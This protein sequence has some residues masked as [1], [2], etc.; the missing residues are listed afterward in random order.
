MSVVTRRLAVTGITSGVGLRLAEVALAAGHRLVGLVRDPD[1][2]DARRLGSL[3]VELVRGDLDDDGALASMARGA[4]AVLHLAA[5]VGD[6]GPAEQFVRVNVGGT[7]R[8]LHAA[9]VS[10]VRRFVHLSSTAVYGRPDRGQVDETWPTKHTGNPYDDTKVDAERLAFS[11]GRE[12]GLEVTAVR[13]PIIYGPYDKNFMP[14]A[15]AALRKGR[16]L[17]VA[18]GKAPLNV[19][20]VDHVV[21]V[22]LRAAAREGAVGEAFN[23]MDEVGGRPPSVVEVGRV[24]A[25]A[26]GAP[27]PTRSLPYPLALGLGHVALRAFTLAR[28]EKPPP[29]TPFV[30][31]ILTRDV[32][33]DASKA[34]RVLGWRPEVRALEGLRR[35]AEAFA[36]REG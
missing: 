10:G 33:Y 15:V 35:E 1:R 31:K 23:V 17:L 24:I 18:G 14:R 28:A 3:G 7:R 21:D 25:E 8:A 29:V 12:T 22:L 9:R 2:S 34:G 11:F 13:P 36:R 4:D 30:V 32:V 27:P 6:W 5:Q 20:W 16:F 26:V 19:V